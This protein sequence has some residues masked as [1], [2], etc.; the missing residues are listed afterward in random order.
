MR[1][2]NLSQSTHF[3][4]QNVSFTT[5]SSICKWGNSNALRIPK[6]FLEIIGIEV[7]DEVEI[8]ISEE[9]I[10]VKKCP[11]NNYKNLQERLEAFYQRPLDEIVFEKEKEVDWGVPEGEEAW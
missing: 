8:S 3:Q 9:N 1:E 4:S 6:K 2:N 10:I 11:K 5:T 7:N